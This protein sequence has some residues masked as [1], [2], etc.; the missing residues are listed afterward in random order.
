MSKAAGF[1]QLIRPINSF[2]MGV[3][4]VIGEIIAIKD[5]PSTP[6]MLLGFITAFFLTAASMV[7]NDYYDRKVDEVN[8]PDRPL[9]SGIISAD[10]ALLFSI[11]L[12]IIGLISASVTN[13][14]CLLIAILG[15]GASFGY[16]TKGKETGLPGN[17]MVSVCVSL[18][19]IYG[20]FAVSTFDTIS[21]STIVFSMMAF[22][23]N[24]GREITKGIADVEGDR[25]R[26][27]KTVA[28]RSGARHAAL[29]SVIFYFSA[30]ALSVLPWIL[31]S[32]TWVYLPIVL[33][34]D[35]GFIYSSVSLLRNS[36]RENSM[37]V[38]NLILICMMLALIAIVIGGIV[39]VQ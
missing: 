15:F 25:L 31:S 21:V 20:G 4:T 3:A 35:A 27:I 14:Q 26:N 37:R 1:A 16:N 32:V 18:P 24:T 28:I 6:S 2:M 36:S 7:V 11:V 22:L 30:I 5:L 23:S 39:N 12:T 17:L 10:E 38:K 8:A 13:L 9:P 29:T 34:S 33:I 19:F